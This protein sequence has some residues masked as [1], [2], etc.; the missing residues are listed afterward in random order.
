MSQYPITTVL[1]IEAYIEECEMSSCVNEKICLKFFAFA[2][3]AALCLF[4]V[5][6]IAVA[7]WLY[8]LSPKVPVQW[9][10]VESFS[11]QFGVTLLATG[12]N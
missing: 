8:Q 9:V 5:A 4:G 2:A 12:R 6:A 3:N 1:D 10:L 11:Y 7:I